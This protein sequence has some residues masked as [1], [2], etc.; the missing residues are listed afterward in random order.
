MS[1]DEAATR[2]VAILVGARLRFRCV[3]PAGFA[4]IGSH[5][6]AYLTYNAKVRQSVCVRE[7]RG[8]DAISF[9]TFDNAAANV[10]A[11][12]HQIFSGSS[13]YCGRQ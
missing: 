12:R 10:F 5:D 3:R 6:G 9:E 13:R 4:S 2:T 7:L 11:R 1:I 8:I